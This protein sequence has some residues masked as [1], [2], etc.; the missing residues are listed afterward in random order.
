M[1]T[2][3]PRVLVVDDEEGVRTFAA[4]VLRDA[5]YDV[6]VAADGVDALRV[7]ERAHPFD[8]FVLDEMMPAMRG[9][10]LACQLWRKNP[11]VK[12]LYFTGF[13]D[14]LFNEKLTLGENEAF[15]AKPVTIKG[16]REAVSLLLFGHICGPDVLLRQ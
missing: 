16:L 9:D 11:D 13:T 8:M 5:G 7:V 1:Q 14:K 12:V 6:M 15:I 3:A 10:E 2:R 4:R